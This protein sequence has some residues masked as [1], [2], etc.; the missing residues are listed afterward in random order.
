MSAAT[1]SLLVTNSSSSSKEFCSICQEEQY[2]IICICGDK[3][4]FTCIH[5]HVAQMTSEFQY[6]QNTVGERLL[7]VEQIVEDNSCTNLSA[8]VENWVCIYLSSI[9]KIFKGFF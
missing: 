2:N 7:Q 1:T 9:V 5:V 6:L 4:C 8:I 3:F